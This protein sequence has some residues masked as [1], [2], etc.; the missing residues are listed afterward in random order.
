MKYLLALCI[1][2]GLVFFGYG[3][4]EAFNQN[5]RITQSVSTTGLV[6]SSD[7]GTASSD[8][9]RPEI[10]YEYDVDNRTYR[11][12]KIFAVDDSGSWSWAADIVD[13]Y[14]KGKEVEIWYD[15]N[16]PGQALL[17]KKYLF[18]PY[19]IALFGLMFC[20]IGPPLVIFAHHQSL[21]P[22][23]PE[24]LPDGW[25]QL[26]APSTLTRAVRS[27]GAFGIGWILAGVLTCGH[28]FLVTGLSDNVGPLAIWGGW[29]LAGLCWIGVGAYALWLYRWM[30]DACVLINTPRP[31]TGQ[32]IHIRIE[33]L[34]KRNNPIKTMRAELVCMGVERQW[35]GNAPVE[36]KKK[37]HNEE[38]HVLQD[39]QPT[40]GETVSADFEFLI[41]HNVPASTP[42]NV[43]A[44][45]R[46]VWKFHLK[47]RLRGVPPC[48]DEFTLCVDPSDQALSSGTELVADDADEV[49][50]VEIV[51]E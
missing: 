48:P 30:D 43:K 29:T 1:P 10:R 26:E 21:G 38:R 2:M 18:F 35:V 51:D 9:F 6:L 19:G 27:F 8:S 49:L 32:T 22:R 28:Y 50:E 39:Y 46:I 4:F 33:Q 5:K 3:V 16:D 36:V 11:S 45:K 42:A 14:G 20:F 25:Y 34:L 40:P 47:T 15:P 37:I 24:Q 17:I 13:Q 23:E 41:P 7:V 44:K 31:V 12:E